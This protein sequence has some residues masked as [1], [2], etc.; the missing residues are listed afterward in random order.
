M[1]RAYLKMDNPLNITQ[2]IKSR[3][4]DVTFGDAK[5]EAV[6]KLTSDNDSVIF[7]GDSVNGAEYIVFNPN[8]IKS[9]DPVTYDSEGNVIPLSQRFDDKDDRIT[10][11][12]AKP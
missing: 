7:D 9:A 10:F 4:E 12:N 3:A 8:Q 11:S 6:S 2:E 1:V 5:R